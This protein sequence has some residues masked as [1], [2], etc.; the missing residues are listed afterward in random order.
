MAADQLTGRRIAVLDD[1][2]TGSQ[3]VHGV[4]VV[5]RADGDGID[6]ALSAPGSTCFVLT[7]SRSLPEAAA[8]ELNAD[9]GR[10][11]LDLGQRLGGRLNI[12]SRSDSTLRGHFIAEVR[13]L[14]GARRDVL[15]AG[16]DGV[17]LVPS[18]FEAGRF[19]VNDVHYARDVPVGET[20]FARDATF[21]YSASN[22][23]D[24]VAEKSGGSIG[25]ADV[26]SIGLEDIRAGGP[27]RV[28]E[29]LRE[30]TGG[31]FVVVNATE[32]A[33]LDVVVLGLLEVE[34]EGRAFLFRSGPSFVRA[35]AGLQAQE[36]LT[37]AE[38]W[39][40]G[41]PGGHGLVVVGSHVSGSTSQVAVARARGAFEEVELDVAEVAD[42]A[43]RDAH[44]AEVGGRVVSAL[45]GADV[46]LVTSRTLARAEDPDA[47]LDISRAVSAAVVDVVRA[48]RGARPAWV[49]AKGGIT[50]HDVAVHGLGIGRAEVAGQL[51]PGLVSV[52]RPI[53][54]PEEVVGVPYVVFAGNVGDEDALAYVTDVL[55]TGR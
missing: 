30:A 5:T 50:S 11:L 43:R 28:A 55:R 44:V 47:S 42:P 33:D 19:T 54:A 38:I 9:L 3:T 29:I 21:G 1:D 27:A 46:L 39:P 36:P 35:L 23:R 26:H 13:A 6:A 8:I 15:G 2:P 45:G 16:Y 49:V 17:L 51:L 18:Y 48:A 41:H 52:F 25:V 20:E 14:D 10:S 53:E 24:F 37:A 12:V 7:N 22:L 32:Y 40:D 34:A 4:Q 31:A